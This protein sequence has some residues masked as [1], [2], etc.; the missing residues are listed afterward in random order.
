MTIATEWELKQRDGRHPTRPT[1]HEIANDDAP[2]TI[3]PGIRLA[4][5]EGLANHDYMVLHRF[6]VDLLIRSTLEATNEPHLAYT[7][8]Y[9]AAIIEALG[10]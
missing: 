5:L 2:G 4:F 9:D 7:F 10:L 8:D 3:G 1:P 6:D